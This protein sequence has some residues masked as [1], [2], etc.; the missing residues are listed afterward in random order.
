MDDKDTLEPDVAK[1]YYLSNVFTYVYYHYL[2]LHW[3]GILLLY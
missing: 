1:C 2:K 3:F